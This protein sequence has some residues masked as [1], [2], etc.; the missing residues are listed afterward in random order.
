M[1]TRAR[2]DW[3]QVPGWTNLV[4]AEVELEGPLVVREALD[5]APGVE[6]VIVVRHR[7]EDEVA[8]RC[9]AVLERGAVML[10]HHIPEDVK[11][12]GEE[13]EEEEEGQR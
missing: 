11:E 12:E 4:V 13:E 1:Q 7:A 6:P 2:S 9:G 10:C 3:M 8:S 5:A